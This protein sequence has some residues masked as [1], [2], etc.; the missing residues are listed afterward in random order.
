M[1][2]NDKRWCFAWFSRQR[3]RRGN[4]AVT[5]I[6]AYQKTVATPEPASERKSLRPVR[7]ENCLNGGVHPINL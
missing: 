1:S 3:D 4:D 5:D 6:R 2:K 7:N